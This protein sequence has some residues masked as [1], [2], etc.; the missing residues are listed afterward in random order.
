MTK[1]P[2]Q[3]T[4]DL[5]AHLQRRVSDCFAQTI[6]L[7]SGDATRQFVIATYGLGAA[8]GFASGSY[9]AM[10]GINPDETDPLEL[11]E[12]IIKMLREERTARRP[13]PIPPI[14]RDTSERR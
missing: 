9:A 1:K 2:D 5:G 6:S 7:A 4:M 11:A 12:V 14:G 8:I 13:T 3:M 10:K